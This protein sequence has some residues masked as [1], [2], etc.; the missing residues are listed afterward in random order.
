MHKSQ[1]L[2][3]INQGKQKVYTSN[4]WNSTK[5]EEQS[6][7][8][9]VEIDLESLD[10]VEAGIMYSCE[11]DGVEGNPEMYGDDMKITDDWEKCY[12]YIP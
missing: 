1:K 10:Q 11:G 6:L 2:K 12:I 4:Q 9:F 3:L 5:K 7:V 8:P